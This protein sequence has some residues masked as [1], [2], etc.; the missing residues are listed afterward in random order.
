MPPAATPF[1]DA[2]LLK[3]FPDLRFLFRASAEKHP[4]ASRDV[5][6]H[7]FSQDLGS[8]A[9]EARDAVDVEDDVAVVLRVAD[10]R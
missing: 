3:E 5:G 1:H 7:D 2:A 8:R 4:H 10:A 6:F 9:V